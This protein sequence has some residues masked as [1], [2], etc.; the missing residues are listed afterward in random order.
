[1]WQPTPAV[2]GSGCLCGIYAIFEMAVRGNRVHLADC[3]ETP[4]GTL[5]HLPDRRAWPDQNGSRQ[6]HRRRPSQSQRPSSARSDLKQHDCPSRRLAGQEYAE[7]WEE[8]GEAY[9]VMEV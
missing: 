3:L 5:F 6:R 1:M 2:A 4:G 9:G 7:H 8:A